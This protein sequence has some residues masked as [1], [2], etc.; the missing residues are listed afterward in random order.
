MASV[1]SPLI[2]APGAPIEGGH[3]L[4][5]GSNLELIEVGPAMF[6]L[7]TSDRCGVR[8]FPHFLPTQ[9]VVN[10]F[11]F[12]AGARG[13]LLCDWEFVGTGVTRPFVEPR[14]CGDDQEIGARRAE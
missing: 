11:T 2:G 7:L 12:E 10:L 14:L 5:S 4:V 1:F 13:H 9:N 6:T 8:V 3:G